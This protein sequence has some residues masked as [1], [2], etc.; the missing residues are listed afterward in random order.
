M[1]SMEPWSS[2]RLKFRIGADWAVWGVALTNITFSSEP[3]IAQFLAT[4]T[5]VRRLSPEVRRART[6][7]NRYQSHSVEA[8]FFFFSSRGRGR[9][10]VENKSLT[11]DHDAAEL[12]PSQRVN[13]LGT[14]WLHQVLHHQQ[15]QETHVFLHLP[16][17]ERQTSEITLTADFSPCINS[18]S[19]TVP[20]QPLV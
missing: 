12:S 7:S 17:A 10:N 8:R 14:L 9:E 19:C 2:S 6:K 15:A 5:A 20:G 3:T 11:G 1:T 13:N 18:P 16:T 4:L